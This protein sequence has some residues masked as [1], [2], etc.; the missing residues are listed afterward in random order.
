MRARHKISASIAA[1]TAAL[2]IGSTYAAE[3]AGWVAELPSSATIEVVANGGTEPTTL[4]AFDVLHAGDRLRLAPDSPATGSLRINRHDGSEQRIALSDLPITISPVN[5]EGSR[6]RNLNGWLQQ[7]A[8]RMVELAP[9]STAATAS[10]G[11]AEIAL[12]LARD[13]VSCI[14]QREVPVHLVWEGGRSPYRISI[15]GPAGQLSLPE[16]HHTDATVPLLAWHVGAHHVT[17]TDAGGTQAEWLIN[18]TPAPSPAPQDVAAGLQAL[19]ALDTGGACAL[20]AAWQPLVAAPN[21]D[22]AAAHLRAALRGGLDVELL[23]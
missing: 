8:S 20:L 11:R 10:R 4:T 19:A 22:S 12:P 7:V 2:F 16:V 23:R 18:V 6:W 17:I 3:E 21:D 1:F 5:T 14:T 9:V 13:G 15:D